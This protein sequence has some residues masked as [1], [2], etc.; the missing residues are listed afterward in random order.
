MNAYDIETFIEKK[1]DI[2]IAFC[3]C[4]KINNKFYDFYYESENI[5]VIQK[6]IIFMFDNFIDEVVYIHNINFD[7]FL[8]INSISKDTTIKIESLIRENN[9]YSITLKKN[10]K[11][12]LFKCSY[13]L[14]PESLEKISKSFK[15]C[16][17]MV[18]PYKF[19]T[20]DSLFYIGNCPPKEFFK[21]LEDYHFFYKKNK[22]FDFKRYSID[23]CK[24][25]V[26][27]TSLF[28]LKLHDI[29]KKYKIDI[30]KC[31]SAP[32]LSF[33]IFNKNYNNSK[34]SFNIKNEFDIFIRKSYLGGR[35]E[36]Y[37]NPYDDD[38]IFQYDFSGMYAQCMREK[39]P[40]GRM[41]I[42]RNNFNL[43][44]PG[45]YYIKYYSDMYLPIL[46]HKNKNDNK[47]LFVNGENEGIFWFEEINLFLKEGGKILEISLA[48]IY[49]KY[50]YVFKDFVEYFTKIREIDSVH[51]TF[52]KLIINSLYGRMGMSSLKTD[53]FFVDSD[54]INDYLNEKNVLNIKKINKI[55]LIEI[56]SNN[57]I[58]TK[59]NVGIASAITSKARI[60]LYNAQK[61]VINNGG[62]LLYSDTDSIFAS[63]KRN[64]V[65]EIHGEIEWKNQNVDNKIIDGIFITSKTY[66]ISSTKKESVK[67][68]GFDS[69]ETNL[70][71]MKKK[72]YNNENSIEFNDI[73]SISKKNLIL[74]NSN[75]K[76]KLFLL[77]YNKRKFINNK[78]ETLPLKKINEYDYI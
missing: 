21:N 54:K 76:K 25:D 15:L 52:G 75:V 7:G 48:I 63:F 50:D 19:S 55:A 64:V 28:V 26:E 40:F 20:I 23:Y 35:C 11:K 59:N 37:G 45:F 72:F 13:K 36:V 73:F 47:L 24:N 16:D 41:Y 32:S 4:F 34:L 29:V 69:K 49:D 1:K 44:V 57:I 27:I 38:F 42:I 70:A 78:K 12:I 9:I 71:E 3:V 14:L 33:K 17:K 43:S 58:K 68:K 5:C 61:S 46:P 30:N 6:S 67:I 53:S 18:F 31:F 10:N 56:E 60:K 8:I 77:N 39:F 22:K 51:K 62:R 65:N 74:H 66:A 2:F